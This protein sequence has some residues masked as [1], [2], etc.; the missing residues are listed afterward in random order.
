MGDVCTIGLGVDA[1][2]E[3]VIG[4]A[5]RGGGGFG[6]QKDDAEVVIVACVM[7]VGGLDL[8]RV[9]LG[10]ALFDIKPESGLSEAVDE[11]LEKE[12]AEEPRPRWGGPEITESLG[13]PTDCIKYEAAEEVMAILAAERNM[14]ATRPDPACCSL[15]GKESTSNTVDRSSSSRSI[16]G[17]A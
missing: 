3:E 7:S 14:D 4:G 8:E 10:K 5:E 13:A 6:E 16:G 9:R 12:A 2:P 11:D 17:S 15:M 1:I